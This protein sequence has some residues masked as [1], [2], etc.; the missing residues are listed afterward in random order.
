MFDDRLVVESPG[1]LPGIVRLSNMRHV[2]F[3]RNPKIAQFLHEYEYVQEFGEGVDRLY[4]VMEAAGL[5]QPEYK[6]EAF[7]LNATIRNKVGEKVG[8]K[9]GDRVGENMLTENQKKIIALMQENPKISAARIAEG[10]SIS[11][12][13]VEENIKKL[14]AAGKIER[15]GTARSGRW[16]VL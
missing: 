5:P 4:E 1:T 2:H 8:E 9:V 6:V 12:R 15:I 10:I 3:S 16:N 13:K 14:K 7:M 11:P